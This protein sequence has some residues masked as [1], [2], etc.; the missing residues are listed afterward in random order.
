MK[1]KECFIER[2]FNLGNYQSV[3]IG[4]TAS[5]GEDEKPLEVAQDIEYLIHQH[6]QTTSK[7]DYK[8]STTQT[9]P[10]ADPLRCPKCGGTKK[11]QYPLCYRCQYPEAKP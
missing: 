5:I 3:K 11:T 6:Y 9:I 8:P 2:T 4:F 10:E 7:P 1:T